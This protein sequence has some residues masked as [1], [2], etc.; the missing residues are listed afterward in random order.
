LYERLGIGP[1]ASQ[2]DIRSAYRSL[3]RRLHPD[4]G[5]GESAAAMAA[6]NEAWR[7]LGDPDRRASYDASLAVARAAAVTPTP[8]VDQPL[9]RVD[10]A[11]DD[12]GPGGRSFWAVA[13]PWMLVLVV[14][15]AIFLFTAYAR[16]GL[17]GGTTSTPA[18]RVD[19]VIEVDSCIVLDAGARALE[20]PCAG[21]HL[22]VV[23]AIVG[24]GV[25][26]PLR[27]EGFY[28]VD[29]ISLVCIK[30]D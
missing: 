21:P 26:C 29:G 25:A 14:L 24:R 17:G 1:R 11:D 15:G 6:V 9:D 20:V 4:H 10:T 27:T 18:V 22:G 13:L 16:G 12:D 23:N 8:T 30:R 7:V 3:A 19:G 28:S 2:A 5:S